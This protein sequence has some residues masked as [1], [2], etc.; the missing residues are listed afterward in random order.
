M[1]IFDKIVQLVNDNTDFTNDEAEAA[2]KARDASLIVVQR[3]AL[4]IENLINEGNA[5]D[6]DLEGVAESIVDLANEFGTAFKNLTSDQK[7]RVK[8]TVAGIVTGKNE[9]LIETLFNAT[10]DLVGTAQALVETMD[11][12]LATPPAEG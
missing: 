9:G 6:V 11:R 5:E 2:V 1:A 7:D 4:L 8:A 12:L 10:L 3:T